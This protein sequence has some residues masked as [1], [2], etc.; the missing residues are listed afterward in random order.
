[1]PGDHEDALRALAAFL[2]ANDVG[3][4]DLAGLIGVE[5]HVLQRHVVPEALELGLHVVRRCVELVDLVR[6][7]AT[8]LVDCR[9]VRAQAGLVHVRNDG[10]DVDVGLLAHGGRD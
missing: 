10:G 9:D 7:R 3:R 4:N 2:D 5:L 1:M 6:E 8:W